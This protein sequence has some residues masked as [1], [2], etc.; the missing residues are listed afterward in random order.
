MHFFFTYDMFDFMIG[1]VGCKPIVSWETC[2][3]VNVDLHMDT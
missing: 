2:I 1:L 3:D